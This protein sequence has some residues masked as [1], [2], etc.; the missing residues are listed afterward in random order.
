MEWVADAGPAEPDAEM[1]DRSL[2]EDIRIVLETLGGREQEV[3]RLYFGLDDDVTMTL[4]EIG[5]RLGLTRERIRQIKKRA[6]DKLRHPCRSE[7]LMP[8]TES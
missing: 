2:R 3:I 5:K 1:L 6:L 7:R 8:Y 4:A